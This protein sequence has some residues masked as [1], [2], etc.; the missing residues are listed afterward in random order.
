MT[1]ERQHYW[2]C[3]T[4]EA[5][6]LDP[7][8]R[9]G[10]AEER[11]HYLTHE[12]AVDDVGYRRFLAKLAAPLLERLPEGARGLDFGCGPGPALAAML[13]EAGHEVAL[14]DPAFAPNEAALAR[15]YDFIT[16]TEVLEHLFEPAQI[17][18]RF[19]AMLRPGGWLGL[20]TCFQTDDARFAN[21]S[22]RREPTHVVFYRRATLAR[23][24]DSLG[25]SCAFPMKDVA[26]MRKPAGE[27]A[28]PVRPDRAP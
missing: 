17:F 3:G 1:V 5:T 23:I 20:M 19:D 14:Y 24:A 28:G 15:R 8:Q 10:R 2:R 9:L 6:F 27:E 16:C 21:W 7:S 22:Y 18:D 25:W 13:E 11:A 4:C 12:N 26:L